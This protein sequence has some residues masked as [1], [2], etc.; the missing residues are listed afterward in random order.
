M[1][2]MEILVPLVALA[3]VYAGIRFWMWVFRSVND[4]RQSL[5]QIATAQG[6]VRL[7]TT[8]LMKPVAPAKRPAR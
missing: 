8:K 2:G 7:D 3:I 1:R 4:M 5:K 6:G